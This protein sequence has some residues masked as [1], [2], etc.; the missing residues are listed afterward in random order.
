ML[1]A[2]QKASVYIDI[3]TSK[4]APSEIKL[5][6][7]LPRWLG[8]RKPMPRSPPLI[9]EMRCTSLPS[10]EVQKIDGI[11]EIFDINADEYELVC[12][13]W[14]PRIVRRSG[15]TSAT[16][17][18]KSGQKAHKKIDGLHK[19][20][21]SN[22]DEYE[23]V[24]V[25]WHPRIVRQ[26]GVTSATWGSKSGQKACNNQARHSLENIHNEGCIRSCIRTWSSGWWVGND[27]HDAYLSWMC[28]GSNASSS[29]ASQVVQLT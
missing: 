3:R 10:S 22:V 9:Y 11:H 21:D 29:M 6:E 25:R 7:I 4:N 26:S 28:I 16:W 19:I 1:S 20:F 12:I 2:H 8:D 5:Q 24:C 14:H 23:L 15:V 18:S 27:V 17:G 13:R